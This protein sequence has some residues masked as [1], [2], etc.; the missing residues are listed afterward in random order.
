MTRTLA[1]AFP[2]RVLP[3]GSVLVPLSAGRPTTRRKGLRAAVR[4]TG[5]GQRRTAVRGFVVLGVVSVT[6]NTA[7]DVIVAFSASGVRAG[8]TRRPHLVRRLHATSGAAMIALG[9]GLLLV[10]RPA[11]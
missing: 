10:R 8:T 7:A 4:Q 2:V 9:L 11:V 5:R 1:A 6:L 3:P